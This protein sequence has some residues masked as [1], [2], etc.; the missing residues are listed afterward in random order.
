[1]LYLAG[2]MTGYP[3]WNY[4]AFRAAAAYL[5]A[6]DF[7]VI[8]PADNFDGRTDL[9]WDTY[10]RMAVRQVTESDTVLLLPGWEYS[11]GAKLERHVALELGID[12]MTFQDF[13]NLD[14]EPGV[15]GEP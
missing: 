10:L 9:P 4:P 14:D 7:Q 5:R 11:K 12:V 3:D 8:N 15:E 13:I 2:P 1:M 6:L